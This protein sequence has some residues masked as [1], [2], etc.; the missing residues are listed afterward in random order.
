MTD[1]RHGKEVEWPSMG[2]LVKGGI[3]LVFGQSRTIRRSGKRSSGRSR[4]FLPSFLPSF[5]VNTDRLWRAS[6]GTDADLR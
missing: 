4:S 6:S 5:H 3:P 1:L 2:D